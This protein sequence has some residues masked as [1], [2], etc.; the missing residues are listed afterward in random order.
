M[1]IHKNITTL[2][3]KKMKRGEALSSKRTAAFE[4]RRNIGCLELLKRYQCEHQQ[5]GCLMAWLWS[6]AKPYDWFANLKAQE[7]RKRHQIQEWETQRTRDT[8]LIRFTIPYT[9]FS[10]YF[11]QTG[12]CLWKRMANVGECSSKERWMDCYWQLRAGNWFRV[13]FLWV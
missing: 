10:F 8:H 12:V 1:N 2:E 4:G 11:P 9:V 6:E 7:T 3:K 5:H 13:E